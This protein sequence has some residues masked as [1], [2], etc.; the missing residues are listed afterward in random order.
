MYSLH[1]N[2]VARDLSRC[3]RL[4]GVRKGEAKRRYTSS[5]YAIN[6]MGE[7]ISDVDVI[8]P[9]TLVT[10]GRSAS[11]SRLRLATVGA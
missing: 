9:A 2:A 7:L 1:P 11:K 6:I 10:P 5:I 4:A 3:C 8:S